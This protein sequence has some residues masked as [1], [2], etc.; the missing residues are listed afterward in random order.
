MMMVQIAIHKHRHT[1]LTDECY[2][3]NANN[4]TIQPTTTTTTDIFNRFISNNN[5]KIIME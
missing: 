5:N 1:N 2:E 3:Y 4:A